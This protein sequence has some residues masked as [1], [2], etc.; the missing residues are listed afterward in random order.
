MHNA[1]KLVI[2]FV[3]LCLLLLGSIFLIAGETQNILTGAG[4]IL[5]A[6]ALLGY[7]YAGSRLEAKRPIQQEFHVTMGGSGE[8]KEHKMSCKS[9]GGALQEKDLTVVKGG[10]MVKCPYC[11]STYAL[12]EEPKW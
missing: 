9:C 2:I 8:L 3:A 1:L 5:V 11:G 4:I 6:F 7:I 12:E 10:V